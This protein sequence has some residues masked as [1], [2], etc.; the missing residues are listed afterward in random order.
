MKIDNIRI[1]K[2]DQEFFDNFKKQLLL[3]FS[4]IGEFKKFDVINS[5]NYLFINI[6]SNKKNYFPKNTYTILYSYSNDENFYKQLSKPSNYFEWSID[7]PSEVID[8]LI[9]NI[10]INSILNEK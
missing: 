7:L 8:S 3:K 5:H 2:E 6:I 9:R 10:K 4:E 1:F